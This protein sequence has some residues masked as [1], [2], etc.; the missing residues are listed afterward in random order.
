MNCNYKTL[1]DVFA[2]VQLYMHLYFICL[3]NCIAFI[4]CITVMNLHIK[5]ISPIFMV[6]AKPLNDKRIFKILMN[7]FC[8]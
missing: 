2:R 1:T 8:Y 6:T 7:F 4:F 5:C 3:M